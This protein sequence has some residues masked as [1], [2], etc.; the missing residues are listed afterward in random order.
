[1]NLNNEYIELSKI[2]LATKGEFNNLQNATDERICNIENFKNFL[3]SK[4]EILDNFNF[5]KSELGNYIEYEDSNYDYINLVLTELNQLLLKKNEIEKIIQNL[6]N[7]F[8]VD[9]N[10]YLNDLNKITTNCKTKMQISQINTFY[11]QL[12]ELQKNITNFSLLN[13]ELNKLKNN[14]LIWLEDY[15]LLKNEII[16]IKNTHDFISNIQNISKK[17]NEF[18][19][20]KANDIL[21]FETKIKAFIHFYKNRIDVFKNSQK[22]FSE[23]IL[24]QSTILYEEEERMNKIKKGNG[25]TQQPKSGFFKIFK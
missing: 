10:N 12:V 20:K 1:M 24:L 13:I 14:S 3:I 11:L 2:L 15:E 17:V 22:S 21:T 25:Q 23:F 16:K 5:I 19:N 6:D 7:F 18:Q 9:K 8:I 4:S